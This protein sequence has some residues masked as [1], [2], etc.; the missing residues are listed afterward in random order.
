MS[1]SSLTVFQFHTHTVRTVL[2]EQ[3]EPWFVAADVCAALTIAHTS[4]AISRLPDDEKGLRKVQTSGGEQALAVISES[5]AYR[6]TFSSRKPEAKAFKRWL[7]HEVLPAIVREYG[8]TVID[9]LAAATRKDAV[10]GV[11]IPFQ[12]GE[13]PIRV[14]TDETGVPLFVGKDICDALGYVDHLDAMKRHC[15]GAVKRRP[16]QTLGGAQELRVLSEPDVMRLI[17]SSKLPAAEAFERLVFEEI[18]PTIRKT[19]TY[20]VHPTMVDL[21]KQARQQ[22]QLT[23]NLETK[24]AALLDV[25]RMIAAVPGV[26]ASMA[27]AVALTVIERETG[28]HLDGFRAALPRNAEP[29]ATLNS[30]GLG[31]LIQEPAVTT[32]RLLERLGLQRRN[33]RGEWELTEAGTQHGEAYPYTNGRHSGYQILWKPSVVAILRDPQVSLYIQ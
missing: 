18:L 31:A 30:T 1:S 28:L 15:K 20:T 27:A 21:Q 19:G 7:A 8:A 2:D 3:G 12:F 6:L 24:V 14:V 10:V 17:V 26:K 23:D 25:Q 22:R 5:G 32:N 13:K 11:I 16:L 9:G 4:A 29:M 33:A